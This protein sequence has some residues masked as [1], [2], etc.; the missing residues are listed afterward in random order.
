MMIMRNNY[1]E[2][3]VM[4]Y[5]MMVDVRGTSE[6]SKYYVALINNVESKEKNRFA[7]DM[8]VN[9]PSLL[10]DEDN[11]EYKIEI[12]T[13]GIG[14]LTLEEYPKY[15][16]AVQKAYLVAQELQEVLDQYIENN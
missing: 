16:E 13:S 10:I 3:N 14:S 4:G 1:Q 12:H 15:V 6:K 11:T 2:V 5:T 9:S 7:P 8:S